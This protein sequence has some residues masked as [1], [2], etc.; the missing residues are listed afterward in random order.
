MAA[1]TSAS[2]LAREAQDVV[3]VSRDQLFIDAPG[4]EGFEQRP[5]I[6]WPESVKAALREVGDA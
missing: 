3:P 5:S 2:P 1:V 6:C 4:N